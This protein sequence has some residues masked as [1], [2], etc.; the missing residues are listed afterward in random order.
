MLLNCLAVG[1]GGFTTFS[2]FS[3]E[4]LELME[5]GKPLLF[6]VYVGASVVLCIAGVL[7][8]KWIAALVQG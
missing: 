7:L 6:G 8:G 4:S 2:A 5:S 3:L 1:A